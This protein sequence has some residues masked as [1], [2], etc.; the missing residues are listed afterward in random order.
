M[1]AKAGERN[2]WGRTEVSF[3]DLWPYD[4]KQGCITLRAVFSGVK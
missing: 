1:T 2:Y 3:C 4:I